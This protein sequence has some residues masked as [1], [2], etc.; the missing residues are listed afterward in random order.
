[1]RTALFTLVKPEPHWDDLH[2]GGFTCTDISATITTD[3]TL[4]T[5]VDF[6]G[7][8][9]ITSITAVV[10]DLNEGVECCVLSINPPEAPTDYKLV[11]PST[12][13]VCIIDAPSTPGTPAVVDDLNEGVECCVLS[14][15]PPE[16]PTDYKLVTPSTAKVCIIDAPSTPGTPVPCLSFG[17][18]TYVA[19]EGGDPAIVEVRASDITTDPTTTVAFA[20]NDVSTSTTDYAVD[21]T[22]TLPL[23]FDAATATISAT[24]SLTCET[25]GLAESVEALEISIAPDAAGVPTYSLCTPSTATL[26]CLDQPAAT[27]T[28]PCVS[29]DRS[30]YVALEG[31]DPALV[32]VRASGITADPGTTV[33]F[34][35]NDVS[36]ST[37]DYTVDP[38]G[39]LLLTFD[40]AT[41]TI[42]A[43]ISLTCETEGL[44]EG[45][46]ALEISITPDAA[47]Y[48][49]CT[50]STATLLCLD[51]PAATDTVPC[52]SFDRS[53]YV[54]LEG[55]DPALVEV[56][57]S[58]ITTDPG[59]TVAFATNDVTTSTTDYTVDATGTIPLTFDAA[60]ATISALIS[61]TCETDDLVEVVEALE[62]SIAPASPCTPS[63]ATVICLDPPPATD[64]GTGTSPLATYWIEFCDYK[65]DESQS[66]F[67]FV[68]KRSTTGDVAT[69]TCST[70]DVSATGSL[71]FEPLD[72]QTVTFAA[73]SD[74]T[75]C[76]VIILPDVSQEDPEV[77]E[78]AISSPSTGELGDVNKAT[79]TIYDSSSS[80]EY[81][82]EI[83]TEM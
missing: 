70:R 76:S 45:S 17:R 47:A 53:T 31:G 39:T 27:D 58:G 43:T 62:I 26:L 69:I 83:I 29:F 38:T 6:T 23:T 11:T 9:G 60:T 2:E 77:F 28:V 3:Y 57:A 61:V 50:P 24:I 36:T 75:T 32:E 64:T 56:R 82:R 51:P 30:T 20:T 73:G 72:G 54:A 49:L 55:G 66:P 44:A 16:A 34:A 15:N 21:P 14:I 40:A 22:G 79:V 46:E 81:L 41:A 80:R 68:I 35:T 5:P 7:P 65:A 67:T 33:A 48:S 13:K 52:V 10:D 37:S 59:T 19:L 8:T 25:D 12:A 4:E 71:D 78:I 18:S 63:T 42:S 74:S 1:M